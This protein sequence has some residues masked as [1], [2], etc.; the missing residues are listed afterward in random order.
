[1]KKLLTLLLAF[2]LCLTLAAPV[3]ATE[4]EEVFQIDYTCG[5]DMTWEFS[6]GTLTISGSGSMYD[7]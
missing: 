7:F 6:N 1:M 4:T 5:D 2:S 3:F